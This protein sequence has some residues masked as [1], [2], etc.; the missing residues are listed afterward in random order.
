MTLLVWDGK[1]IMKDNYSK[2]INLQCAVC[3]EE[4]F[5][6]TDE[7]TGVI[8]C[9]KCN[10]IYPGGF[11]ELVGYNQERIDDEVDLTR[12]EIQKDVNLEIQNMFKKH[13]F[14]VR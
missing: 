9:L 5:F 4:D 10:K 12:E 8:T 3:G 1:Q 7:Q 13:G 2:V 14:K 11:D 6:E